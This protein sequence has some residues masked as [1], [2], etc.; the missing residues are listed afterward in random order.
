[1]NNI[2][3]IRSCSC[4]RSHNHYINNCDSLLI[5]DI[6]NEIDTKILYLCNELML[7]VHVMRA[8]GTYTTNN[9][10]NYIKTNIN[11]WLQNELKHNLLAICYK[12]NSMICF[13][14]FTTF[15]CFYL[16]HNYLVYYYII[17]L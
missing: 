16:N 7:E 2:Q 13:F 9:F 11:S 14:Y 1:M 8:Q 10:N 17:S 12:F 5:N 3:T 4:C 15:I 6:M